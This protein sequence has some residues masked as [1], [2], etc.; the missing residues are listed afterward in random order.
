M[1]KDL[2]LAPPPPPLAR[3]TRCSVR[4]AVCTLLLALGPVALPA[5]KHLPPPPK[6]AARATVIHPTPLYVQGDAST[7]KLATI[8]PGRE[9][10]IIER[11][12]R[13]LRVYAN[14][15]IETVREQDV[16]AF[17]ND[18]ATPP[19]SGWVEEQGIVT[20]D[21][22]QGDAILFGEAVSA[23][24]AA[25]EPHAPPGVAEDARRLYRMTASIFPQSPRA[26]E[27]AWR[28][29]DIRWQLQK[30]DAATLPSAHEKENYLRQLPDESEMKRIQKL[31]PGSKWA[32]YA[33]YQVLD[34]KLC[35]DWQGAEK[36]P[37]K[38]ASYYAKYADERPESPRAAEALYKAAWRLACAGDMWVADGQEKKAAEDRAHA[39]ELAGRLAS[40][41][42]QTDWAARA[43]G[44]VYK[45][46]QQIAIYGSDRE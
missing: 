2:A 39:E 31:Y 23:E 44:L 20:S 25:S 9:M 33:A 19:I 21:T 8:T 36:C 40:K 1:I 22:P 17:S 5:Q 28:S 6:D 46:Q 10:V 42:G 13:W 29:A 27:A 16:P 14:T 24:Q 7:E 11:S 18:Q 3:R 45:V 34:N 38:E 37:E 43:A 15:D 12:S 26:A 41:Y 30:A 4:R 32:D 35:G